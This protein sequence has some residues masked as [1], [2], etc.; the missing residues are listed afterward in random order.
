MMATRTGHQAYYFEL[1]GTDDGGTRFVA[2][3]KVWVYENSGRANWELRRVFRTLFDGKC[4]GTHSTDVQIRAQKATWRQWFEALGWTFEEKFR[5]SLKAVSAAG[6]MAPPAVEHWQEEIREEPSMES[7]AVLALLVMWVFW[8]RRRE[9]RHLAHLL[10]VAM[11]QSLATPGQVATIPWDD[12]FAS[13]RG[14]CSHP[15]PAGECSHASPFD[16]A[17]AGALH[18]RLATCL[19]GLA[20]SCWSC[21]CAAK[22]L[23]LALDSLATC[24]TA[25]LPSIGRTNPLKEQHLKVGGRVA[26]VD[27][28]YRKAVASARTRG[29]AT[30]EAAASVDPELGDPARQVRRW[31]DRAIQ[32]HIASAIEAHSSGLTGVHSLIED[33]ARLG[34]P[35]EETVIYQH[36]SASS[37]CG[38]WLVP[39]AL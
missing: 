32:Q 17:G 26:R 1:V 10:L 6:V 13:H 4:T 31:S 15:A 24:I 29:V 7:G 5:P 28:D 2:Q 16:H 21:P 25:T 39:Q 20:S 36:W 14:L 12:W 35:A 23:Q 9:E 37:A 18:S 34:N 3:C 27:E 8:R 11:L 33:A 19:H 30:M 38:H 22:V